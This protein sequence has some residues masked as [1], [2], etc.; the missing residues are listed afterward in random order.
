MTLS[1]R[2]RIR[3]RPEEQLQAA[4]NEW[5]GWN[6][7][8]IRAIVWHTP[9][10]RSSRVQRLVLS[11]MGVKAGI[12]DFVVVPDRDVTDPRTRHPPTVFIEVK[13]RETKGRLSPEQ[14]N[15]R[16]EALKHG[17]AYEV[18]RSLEEF[19]EIFRRH[20]LIGRPY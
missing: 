12:S 17:H 1:R 5:L 2:I 19:E 8:R 6:R 20:N 11:L 16:G 18:A 4:M 13:C 3:L 15:F 14:Q 9:N 7:N 10:Q